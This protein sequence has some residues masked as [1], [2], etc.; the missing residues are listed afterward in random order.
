MQQRVV[1]T[2]INDLQRMLA[3]WIWLIL[4]ITYH[5]FLSKNLKT[6]LSMI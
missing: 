2:G 6:I 1:I 4:E 5:F 3:L